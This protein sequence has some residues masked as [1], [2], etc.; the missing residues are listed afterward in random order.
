M[1]CIHTDGDALPALWSLVDLV[2]DFLAD[3]REIGSVADADI[4]F[5]DTVAKHLDRVND[6]LAAQRMEAYRLR[7]SDLAQGDLP[8]HNTVVMLLVGGDWAYATYHATRGWCNA[9]GAALNGTCLGG[10][11]M[12]RPDIPTTHQIDVATKR[13]AQKKKAMA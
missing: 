5:V 6:V 9:T 7:S 1:G 8:P 13:S 10:V 11:W 12:H 2:R 3:L 4:R